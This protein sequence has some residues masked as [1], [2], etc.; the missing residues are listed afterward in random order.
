MSYSAK[1]A[2]KWSGLVLSLALLGGCAN[3]GNQDLAK[4]VDQA[5][6]QAASAQTTAND[7]NAKAEAAMQAANDAKT[8]ADNAA[9]LAK[10]AQFTADSNSKKIDRMFKKSMY[11]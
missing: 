6:Q 8:A 1:N 3:T 10:S 9:G 7:A 11:K 2:L 5:K 4:M